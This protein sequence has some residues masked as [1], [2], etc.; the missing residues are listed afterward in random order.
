MPF[1]VSAADVIGKLRSDKKNRDDGLTLILTEG[2]GKAYV[3][4]DV[5]EEALLTY[6]Q[7]KFDKGAEKDGRQ[8][9][10]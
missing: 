3:A 6:L 2:I 9:L 4:H 5:D 7:K 10:A 8:L 1:A